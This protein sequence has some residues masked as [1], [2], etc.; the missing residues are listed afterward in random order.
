MSFAKPKG[1][2][3]SRIGRA[4]SFGAPKDAHAKGGEPSLNKQPPKKGAPADDWG[5]YSFC[6]QLIKWNNA[7][8]SI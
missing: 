2:L 7:E 6:A 8:F 1:E 5:D 3:T 4:A